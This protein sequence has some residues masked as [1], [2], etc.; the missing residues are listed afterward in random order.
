MAQV[1]VQPAL[2]SRGSTMTAGSVC[3]EEAVVMVSPESALKVL[4]AR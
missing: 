2:A 3:T 1:T 4:P